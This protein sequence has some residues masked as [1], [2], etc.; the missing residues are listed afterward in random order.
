MFVT[1]LIFASCHEKEYEVTTTVNEKAKEFETGFKNAFTSNINPN[2]TWGFNV[3]SQVASSRALSRG[4]DTKA[5]TRGE[6][7]RKDSW[8]DYFFGRTR[9]HNNQ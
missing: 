8:V 9:P 6:I 1:G 7:C 4:E 3:G 5:T 2:Q